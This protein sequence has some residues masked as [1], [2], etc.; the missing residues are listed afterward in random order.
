MGLYGREGLFEGN[1]HLNL[2]E[3]HR[4]LDRSFVTNERQYFYELLKRLSFLQMNPSQK[5]T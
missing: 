5:V 3:L 4:K 2:H 1:F